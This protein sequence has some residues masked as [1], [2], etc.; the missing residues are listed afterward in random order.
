MDRWELID[1]RDPADAT[2]EFPRVVIHSASQLRAELHRLQQREPSMLALEGPIDQGLQIG[3]GGPYAGIRWAEY[4]VSERGGT[5]LADRVRSESRI[6][7][8]SEGDTLAFWPDEL[9]PVEQAIEVIVSFYNNHRLPD[10]IGWKEWD[11]AQSKWIVKPAVSV[12][13]A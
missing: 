3:L 2:E 6:D 8:A 4:P 10:W 1:L 7:F 12:R 11:P 13:S 5:G 9:I